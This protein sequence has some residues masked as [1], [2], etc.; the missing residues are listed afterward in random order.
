MHLL[1]ESLD[2]K[3][4][5]LLISFAHVILFIY[6]ATDH[7]EEVILSFLIMLWR[8]CDLSQSICI[9]TI[10]QFSLI[11]YIQLYLWASEGTLCFCG[12]QP[13][14]ILLALMRFFFS[15]KTSWCL[16]GGGREGADHPLSKHALDGLAQIYMIEIDFDAFQYFYPQNHVYGYYNNL[17]VFW[18]IIYNLGI[19]CLF[20]LFLSDCA[21]LL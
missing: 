11:S 8:T 19:N 18:I 9:M 2:S 4:L 20:L 1:G 14:S 6:F 21:R 12:T 13:I 10:W 15:P 7:Q 17:S 5:I 16:L 3:L